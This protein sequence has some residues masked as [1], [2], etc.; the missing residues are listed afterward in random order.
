MSPNDYELSDV[1][2]I[3]NTFHISSEKTSEY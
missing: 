2:I 1:F 3:Q